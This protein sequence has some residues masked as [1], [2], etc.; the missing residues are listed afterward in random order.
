MRVAVARWMPSAWWQD[1]PRLPAP[2][3]CRVCRTVSANDATIPIDIGARLRYA[4]IQRE[5]PDP[6]TLAEV[7]LVLLVLADRYGDEV[8]NYFEFA[9][10]TGLR[11]SELL[12]LEWGALDF[13][14][15]T[16]VVSRAKV[17]R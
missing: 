11:T 7:E 1:R 9:I 14:R 4:K 16:C 13:V 10:F 3:N 17:R 12:A 5:Q 15:Q 2:S 6:L 8:R